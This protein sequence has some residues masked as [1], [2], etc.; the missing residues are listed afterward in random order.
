MDCKAKPGLVMNPLI[1]NVKKAVVL[2]ISSFIATGTLRY[3]K[4]Q[5]PSNPSAEAGCSRCESFN[6]GRKTTLKHRRNHQN[7]RFWYRKSQLSGCNSFDIWC[8]FC[9]LFGWILDFVRGNASSGCCVSATAWV[10]P[11]AYIDIPHHLAISLCQN[12]VWVFP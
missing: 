2:T 3:E 9:P 1:V 6:L 11:L 7:H 12:R 10:L 5:I 8:I 4:I